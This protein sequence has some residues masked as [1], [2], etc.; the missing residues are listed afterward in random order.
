[1][2]R[3]LILDGFY[4]VL[5]VSSLVFVFAA[6]SS[7]QVIDTDLDGIPDSSDNCIYIP[8][9]SQED[10]GGVGIETPDGIGNACQCGD[11]TG[12]G[13]ANFVD[14]IMINRFIDPALT[15]PSYNEPGNADVNGDG[16]VDSAD[17]DLINIESSSGLSSGISLQ[18]CPN[19]GPLAGLVVEIGQAR[20][21]QFHA[22]TIDLTSYISRIGSTGTL[23]GIT[24]R[25]EKIRGLGVVTFANMAPTLG[26]GRVP[27]SDTDN[28]DDA[29]AKIR[30]PNTTFTIA[31]FS[32][33]GVYT[34]RH[35]VTDGLNS[36]FDDLV[37]TV[38]N[39]SIPNFP[40][41]EGFGSHTI[42]GR[43]G[44]VIYV[45][46]LNDSGPGSLRSAIDTTGPRIV[47]FKVSGN[48]DLQR[49]LVIRN[50]FI[51]IAGQSAPG[52]GIS[53]NN[54]EFRIITHDIVIR[55]LRFRV[56][57][58]NPA[59]L[60]NNSSGLRIMASISTLPLPPDRKIYN[61]II[62]HSS[63][64]WSV[65]KNIVIWS[66]TS[67]ITIQNSILS[68]PLDFS[69]HSVTRSNDLTTG[70]GVNLLVGGFSMGIS[71]HDNLFVSAKA[72]NP[73]IKSNIM[74]TIKNNL[75]YN[76]SNWGFIKDTPIEGAHAMMIRGNNLGERADL[77]TYLDIVNN[78]FK[79]GPITGTTPIA[80]SF[81]GNFSNS[82]P[83][84]IDSK[85]YIEGNIGPD[86][87]KISSDDGGN[88]SNNYQD[89]S[90]FPGNWKKVR[91]TTENDIND[92]RSITPVVNDGVTLVSASVLEQ[93]ILSDVGATLPKRDNVDE[94]II[95]EVKTGAGRIID[96]Q[97]EVGGW[98]VLAS[99]PAPTDTDND[100][101]PD[102][103]EV[104]N[105]FRPTIADGTGD[106][107]GDGYTNVEEYLNG[108]TATIIPPVTPKKFIK[109]SVEGRSDA[110]GVLFA[111]RIYDPSGNSPIKV[112][113]A[114]ADR[115][116]K[117]LIPD[118][119]FEGIYDVEVSARGY[120]GKKYTGVS[121][122]DGSQSILSGSLEAGDLNGDNTINSLDWSIM[123][124]AW[125]NFSTK[126][127]L[128]I[129]NKINSLDSSFLNEN[130]FAT[131][132]DLLNGYRSVIIFGDTQ[133]L[134]S[135]I[136]E[137]DR[138]QDFK[139]M[140]D[141]TIAN[142][143]TENIDFVLHTGDA[144]NTGLRMP[145]NPSECT[146]VP[147]VSESE[148][149]THRLE[150]AD[151]ARGLGCKATAPLGC[152]TS[153]QH[154]RCVSCSGIGDIVDA[155]WNKFNRAWSRL[156]PNPS[157]GWEGI[158]Y[159]IVYGDHD[160]YGP[161]NEFDRAGYGDFYNIAH[162]Q[163]LENRFA[164]TD[165]SFDLE[166]SSPIENSLDGW[167]WYTEFTPGVGTAEIAHAFRFKLGKD[168]VL[169]MGMS[170]VAKP[171]EVNW[172]RGVLDSTT[173]PIV[174]LAHRYT[175]SGGR[176]IENNLLS[177][178]SYADRLFMKVIGHFCINPE[179]GDKKS[180]V[181][182]SFGGKYLDIT[183]NK[184]C[185][186]N[187]PERA[188]LTIVRFYLNNGI[189]SEIEAQTVDPISS[190]YLD[191]SFLTPKI[192]PTTFSL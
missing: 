191:N 122:N 138:Y 25:W 192:G 184:Q 58:L 176:E 93:N 98:P 13:I 108:T 35:N 111:V 116:G 168:P 80:I 104:Q 65:D 81:D 146:G 41:A 135:T 148:C 51:T 27:L 31:T 153:W 30:I 53:I 42:G 121:I 16:I 137:G 173:E 83:F 38:T 2:E 96:S 185:L 139:N 32:A 162:F 39:N 118:D 147:I 123:N 131:S 103:W 34:L 102:I 155:E 77:P 73:L 20:E 107:D 87:R 12:E 149:N 49:N 130:W 142:K 128:N 125:T 57:D 151:R 59:N 145:V 64:S 66:E 119:V 43:G 156:E 75:I 92:L 167:P 158:P 179:D 106:A 50:P 97:S 115:S 169:V 52:D 21:V 101:M 141:W 8:N 134:V 157:I 126:S 166:S 175:S 189:V 48:I 47:M 181:D 129:D 55:Y 9:P 112:F 187:S 89:S 6:L 22:P 163:E 17:A 143:Y 79:P 70:H 171:G 60:S 186:S 23:T 95:N 78:V 177:T 180:I 4:S 154:S 182:T 19:A 114:T 117:I 44:R 76:W 170:V 26:E 174:A 127:D 45:T 86:A 140:I 1:M 165:R 69:I 74:V 5:I 152:T 178:Q 133:S 110:S 88:R 67:G 82:Y 46:N 15:A 120:L 100:G 91:I 62:D 72:R 124:D 56:G 172:Y 24:T 113:S 159:A 14:A 188:Y 150:E 29:V 63:F 37:V 7:A 132:H 94:R 99:T 109:P 190:L 84:H 71:V 85:V 160:N 40:G 164:N 10:T 33:P 54:Y 28:F 90:S 61:I 105:G 3:R 161:E 11:V 136:T 144:I 183:F 36:A 68:E 18:N